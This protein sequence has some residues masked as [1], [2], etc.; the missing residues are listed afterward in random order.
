M[1]RTTILNLLE[2]SKNQSYVWIPLEPGE[3]PQRLR[4]KIQ[5]ASKKMG[6]RFKTAMEGGKLY[7]THIPEVFDPG[8]DVGFAQQVYRCMR[9][10]VDRGRTI[11][12]REWGVNPGGMTVQKAVNRSKRYF[13][14]HNIYTAIYGN[15]GLRLFGCVKK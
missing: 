1:A 10:T 7:V 9:E 2:I 15:T 14:G 12:V 13:P 11:Y 4:A 8:S 6:A 3:T 5:K